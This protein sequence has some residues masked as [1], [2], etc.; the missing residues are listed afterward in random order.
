MDEAIARSAYGMHIF[1]TEVIAN[2]V[3]VYVYALEDTA[4]AIYIQIYL[5]APMYTKTYIYM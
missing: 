4:D 5:H 1:E 2:G 3:Y